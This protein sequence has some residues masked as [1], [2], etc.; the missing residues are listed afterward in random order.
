VHSLFVGISR[1]LVLQRFN[2]LNASSFLLVLIIF[3]NLNGVV[4]FYFGIVAPLSPIILLLCIF[5]TAVLFN[6]QYEKES[7]ILWLMT[8]FYI[9]YLYISS[10]SYLINS[11]NIYYGNNYL[12]T[13]RGYLSSIIIILTFYK[14]TTW[15]IIN[16]EYESFI[17]RIFFFICMGVGLILISSLGTFQ[18]A[19]DEDRA[20]GLF[21][22]PNMASSLV[23]YALAFVL[24]FIVQV[25]RYSQIIYFL[26]IPILFYAVFLTFSKA[27][28]IT[29]P[30]VLL[31]FFGLLLIR[32]NYLSKGQR[33][34]FTGFLVISMIATGF[35]I[36]RF[37]S[38][39]EQL[40]WGQVLR[41]QRTLA[42]LSGEFNEA[43]TSERST[44]FSIGFQLIRDNPL[45]GNGLTSF[46]HYD[47]PVNG[48]HI[49]V[50]NTFLLI[51]GE[52]GI[53]PFLLYIGLMIVLI[54]KSL[55]IKDTSMYILCICILFIY[56]IRVAGTAHTA[57][58]DR[59]SNCLFGVLLG[60]LSYTNTR[61]TE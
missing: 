17:K 60:Y 20:S 29:F 43:T 21:A 38:I 53:L 44:L 36:F 59:I 2:Y 19:I 41:L 28:L 52:S 10:I 40:N 45:L 1:L 3:G 33:R 47:I 18:F 9:L 31:L 16:E 37:S 6:R 7:I 61:Y 39:L 48:K 58:D 54:Y 25:K 34:L 14:L 55:K 35:I 12:L 22:N 32:F 56:I 24:A 11:E 26:L 49:G 4:N 13:V 5:I 42:F 30:L 57:L 51:L 23:L 8:L 27:G 46:H 15:A 50:H